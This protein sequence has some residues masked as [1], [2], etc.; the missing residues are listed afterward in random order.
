M[1][2]PSATIGRH[3][4]ISKAIIDRGC[5]IPE[6]MII[7]E[8]HEQDRQHGFRVTGKRRCSGNPRHAETVDSLYADPAPDACRVNSSAVS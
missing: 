6:G 4:R 5:N 1:V 8:D 2:L 7:G 3:V